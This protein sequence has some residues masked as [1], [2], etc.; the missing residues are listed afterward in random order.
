MVQNILTSIVRDSDGG[1]D[2][3]E[4]ARVE[5]LEKREGEEQLV[6]DMGGR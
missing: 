3:A 6:D 5:P 4:L 1:E 2:G